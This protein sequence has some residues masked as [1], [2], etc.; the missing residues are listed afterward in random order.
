MSKGG[1]QTSSITS[2]YCPCGK[3]T[4]RK[5]IY[6]NVTI[7]IHFRKRT[8]WHICEENNIKRTYTKPNNW[9]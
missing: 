5:I 2:L 1:M 7:C 9:I 4:S 8:Y 6:A 3:P